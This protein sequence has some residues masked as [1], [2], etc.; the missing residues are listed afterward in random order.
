L[1]EDASNPVDQIV[2]AANP[3]LEK[4]AGH[5]NMMSHI[6]VLPVYKE[7]KTIIKENAPHQWYLSADDLLL[8][9]PVHYATKQMEVLMKVKSEL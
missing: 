7:L 1:E 6:S 2:K 8:E 3:W 4:A 5:I 9:S